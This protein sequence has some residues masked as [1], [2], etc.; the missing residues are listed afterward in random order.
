[1]AIGHPCISIRNATGLDRTVVSELVNAQT[2]SVLATTAE[3]VAAAYEQ[4]SNQTGP[5]VRNKNRAAREAWRDPQWWEDY[6]GID[7]PDFNADDVDRELNFLERAKLRREEIIHLAWHGDTPEQ[8]L[9]RLDDEVSISTVR[10]IVA[11]WRTGQKRQR[12]TSQDTE[13]AA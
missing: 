7:D 13:L 3:K 2:D 9:A 10:Q 6:G 8:I 4:L 1:M 5:S 12:K 11:E